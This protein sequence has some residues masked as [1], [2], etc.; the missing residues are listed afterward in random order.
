MD[1]GLPAEDLVLTA[2]FAARGIDEDAYWELI[3]ELVDRSDEETFT[4][5]ERLTLSKDSRARSVGLDVL[6][7]LGA[8]DDHPWK[9]ATIPIAVAATT[10]HDANVVESAIS[11]L[12]H[13]GDERGLEAILKR[14]TDPRVEVRREVALA[15]AGPAGDPPDQRAVDAV[16]ALMDDEDDFVREWATFVLGTQ[17]CADDSRVRRALGTRLADEETHVRAEAL[18]GLARRRVPGTFDAVRRELELDSCGRLVF[19]AAGYLGDGRLLGALTTWRDGRPDDVD[20]LNAWAACDPVVQAERIANHAS[21]LDALETQ[22]SELS[23]PPPVTMCCWL[24]ETEVLL[25]IGTDDDRVW[26]VDQLL[27][28]AQGI[29]LG[30]RRLPSRIGPDRATEPLGASR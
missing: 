23:D 16:I 21:L 5:A 17:F 20:V 14:V 12:G 3:F 10:D 4:S 25:K 1:P 28:R 9:D 13:L 11:A 30:P 27:K 7:R 8:V 26:D 19:E 24:L 6:G 22:T 29:P 15:I 18:V 2:A